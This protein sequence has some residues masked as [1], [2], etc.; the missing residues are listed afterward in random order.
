[1]GCGASAPDAPS[2]REASEPVPQ[3]Q[4]AQQSSQSSNSAPPASSDGSD[5]SKPN[6]FAGSRKASV[7][8]SWKEEIA[9]RHATRADGASKWQK[10]H[11]ENLRK[12][13]EVVKQM[14]LAARETALKKTMQLQIRDNMKAKLANKARLKKEADDEKLRRDEEERQRK[15]RAEEERRLA[16]EAAQRAAE[17]AERK[18]KE[19]EERARRD[20]EERMAAAEEEELPV[21]HKDIAVGKVAP[22]RELF[23]A[24]TVF[25]PKLSEVEL[26]L[27]LIS[28][29]CTGLDDH[30][31]LYHTASPVLEAC[32][33]CALCL[34]VA[35]L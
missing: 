18:K 33:I 16:E 8:D 15:E 26:E 4:V 22:L 1:M 20:E 29:G 28:A 32:V 2:G 34:V 25:D 19:E 17:T 6:D 12:Q 24:M 9:N 35:V 21:L 5:E 3:R 13:E 30:D 14:E 27:L 31:E 7:V 23:R 10:M 11:S